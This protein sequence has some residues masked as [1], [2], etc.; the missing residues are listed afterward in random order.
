VHSQELQ[1]GNTM[2]IHNLFE[3]SRLEWR[4]LQMAYERLLPIR[5]HRIRDGG[6]PRQTTM[7]RTLP[8]RQA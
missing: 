8:R 6:A 3:P 2:R 7:V 1:K 4:S 5:E